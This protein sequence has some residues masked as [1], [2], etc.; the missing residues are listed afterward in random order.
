MLKCALARYG[1]CNRAIRAHQ[2]STINY[3]SVENPFFVRMM[4]KIAYC[5]LECD[6]AS[7][8]CWGIFIV[9]V[10]ESNIDIH[11]QAGHSTI[12]LVRGLHLPRK[13]KEVIKYHYRNLLSRLTRYRRYI[14]TISNIVQRRDSWKSMH[15]CGLHPFKSLNRAGM[16]TVAFSGAH[17]QQDSRS[18]STCINP[19]KSLKLS[20]LSALYSV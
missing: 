10:L 8:D 18:I 14:L 5:G 9:T 17:R 7:S 4:I 12:L 15:N 11:P 1:A 16:P 3:L 6:A 19:R 20:A 2:A 13:R